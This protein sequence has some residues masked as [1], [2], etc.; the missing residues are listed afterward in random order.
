MHIIHRSFIDF[1]QVFGRK[2]I[3]F[4]FFYLLG[5]GCG[6]TG[7]NEIEMMLTEVLT[8]FSVEV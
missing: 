4:F 1:V 6:G 2:G 7:G 8:G 3:V 5:C